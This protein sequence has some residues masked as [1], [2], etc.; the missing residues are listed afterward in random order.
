MVELRLLLPELGKFK[1]KVEKN[2]V[3]SGAPF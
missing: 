1:V 2:A 3:Y